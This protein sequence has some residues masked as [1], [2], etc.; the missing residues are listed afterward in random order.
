VP[1]SSFHDVYKLVKLRKNATLGPLFINA[2]A[3]LPVG[4]WMEAEDHPTKGF[5]HRPGWHCT[6]KPEA[7][8]L[9]VNPKNGCRRVWVRCKAQGIEKFNRPQSQ[10]GTWVLAE[11]LMIVEVLR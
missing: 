6:L 7:P 3:V 5:A 8:H 10:G 2:R 11:R 1:T 9:K 4:E